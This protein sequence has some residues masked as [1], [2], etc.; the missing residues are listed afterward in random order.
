MSPVDFLT[1][2][3]TKYAKQVPKSKNT[4]NQNCN[5]KIETITLATTMTTTA[6]T[7]LEFKW[8]SPKPKKIEKI[9][10][11]SKMTTKKK[12]NWNVVTTAEILLKYFDIKRKFLSI[13]IEKCNKKK[14]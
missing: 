11:N 9:R 4:N 8:Q 2:N 3:N 1:E 13:K 6:T 12:I 14:L 10:K 7:T 5:N